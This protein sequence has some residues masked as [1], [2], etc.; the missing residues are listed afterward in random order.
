M[1][2]LGLSSLVI[3]VTVALGVLLKECG[4]FSNIKKFHGNWSRCCDVELETKSGSPRGTSGAFNSINKL[5]NFIEEKKHEAEKV[6]DTFRRFS[7]GDVQP[8]ITIPPTNKIWT[9]PLLGGTN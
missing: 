7:D 9:V 3:A 6:I 8:T 1:D 4:C 5:Y 2:V